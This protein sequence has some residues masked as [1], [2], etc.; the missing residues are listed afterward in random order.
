MLYIGFFFFIASMKV[1]WDIGN[2]CGTVC[3]D[4]LFCAL[5]KVLVTTP[6]FLNASVP[7]VL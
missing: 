2:L 3:C 7:S 4:E 6:C 5:Q 1:W